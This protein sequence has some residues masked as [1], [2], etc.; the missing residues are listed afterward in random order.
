MICPNN[1]WMLQR[2]GRENII[3]TVSLSGQLVLTGAGE[4]LHWAR[5]VNS[6]CVIAGTRVRCKPVRSHEQKLKMHVKVSHCYTPW[7]RPRPHGL[8]DGNGAT[9]G[10]RGVRSP[11]W[12]EMWWWPASRRSS[13]MQTTTRH[14][15]TPKD[16]P[17]LNNAISKRIGG[18]QPY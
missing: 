5:L 13:Y 17:S 10:R 4:R 9:A 14:M 6:V 3:F 15:S 16:R 12:C 2:L 11:V 8:D 1:V 18:I 7:S